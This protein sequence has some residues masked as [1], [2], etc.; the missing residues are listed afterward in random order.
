MYAT[1]RAL[2]AGIVDYA[3]L[4]PPA[5]LEFDQ[6]FRNFLSYRRSPDAW[7]LGRF[8]CP[9]A[10]L[11]LLEPL[12][13]EIVAET[14]IVRIAG[15]G[16]SGADRRAFEA[17]LGEDL[18]CIEACRRAFG[19][20]LV[21]DVF[22]TRLPGDVLAT[23][24]STASAALLKA[25]HEA[26]D[27]AG[28]A[29][30][31]IFVEFALDA[32]WRE[33]LRH[34]VEA[35]AGRNAALRRPRFG[36]K[37]RTGGLEAKAFPSSEQVATVIRTCGEAGVALKCTAGLHHPIRRYDAGVRA[38]MHG[39]LNVFGASILASALPLGLH[40]VLAILD[41][42]DAR[43][44]HFSDETFGWNDAEATLG[45]IEFARRARAV[46]F[47]SCSFDEPRDDLRRLGWLDD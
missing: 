47:G 15:L 13:A 39:F 22:E 28:M 25:A 16:R 4:F 33:S 21:V 30:A 46:S 19:G 14:E 9:T 18:A 5:Q 42:Q 26:F 41:E 43:H 32:A 36:C 35:I 11:A 6:A 37:L 40:D 27:A 44:F 24:T 1:E 7:M 45:E 10:K 20:R 31:P 29:D 38:H 8:V 2:L 12:R 23:G 3:G 17:G 34:T